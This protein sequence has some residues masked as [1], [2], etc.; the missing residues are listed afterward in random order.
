[1]ERV[2]GQCTTY[3]PWDVTT[4]LAD[5]SAREPDDLAC[6]SRE[7]DVRLHAANWATDLIE[8]SCVAV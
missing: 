6:Q 2:F 8:T 1:M 4:A 5:R 7:V 3:F